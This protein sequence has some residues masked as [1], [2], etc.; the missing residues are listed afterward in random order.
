MQISLQSKGYEIID[1]NS[2]ILFDEKSDLVLRFSESDFSFR[3]ILQ[4]EKDDTNKTIIYREIHG[5]DIIFKCMNFSEIGSGTT[6]P[7]ELA[8][9][10]DRKMYIHFWSNL[11]G[12]VMGVK[13]ARK[14]DYT[15]YMEI[16]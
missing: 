2:V 13:Q 3:L 5:D 4:F 9:F 14:V 12:Q 8:T 16:K 6:N 11:E 15:I 10:H 1:A 7:I